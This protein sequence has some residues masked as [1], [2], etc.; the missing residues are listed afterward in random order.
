[1]ECYLLSEHKVRGYRKDFRLLGEEM[2]LKV[3]KE[4]FR[5]LKKFCEWCEFSSRS[6]YLDSVPFKI[7][8]NIY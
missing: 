7:F 1:M 4:Y 8:S 6:L 3:F 5:R 2:K